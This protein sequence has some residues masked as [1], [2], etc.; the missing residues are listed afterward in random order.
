M[1]FAN[2]QCPYCYSAM[3]VQSLK[4]QSC[5][6]EVRGRFVFSRLLQLTPEQQ[7]FVTKFVIASGSLKEMAQVLEV[8][9]PTVRARLDR[10]IEVLQG[11]RPDD[12]QRRGAILD[13]VEEKRLAPHEAAHLLAQ[14]EAEDKEPGKE[15]P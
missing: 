10:I 15:N 11:S 4:C 9:Y 12:D 1:A 13:A 5:G 2:T 14:S 7:E 8:S 6:T 3:D